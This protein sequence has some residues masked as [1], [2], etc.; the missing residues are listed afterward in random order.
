MLCMCSYTVC[1]PQEFAIAFFKDGDVSNILLKSG[2]Y[3]YT[4]VANTL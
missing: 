4:C 3:C 2:V 1:V